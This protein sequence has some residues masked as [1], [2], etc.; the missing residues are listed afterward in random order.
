MGILNIVALLPLDRPKIKC[1]LLPIGVVQQDILLSVMKLDI[2][3]DVYIAEDLIPNVIQM[4]MTNTT[5]VGATL[6]E[7][8]V[9]SWPM[10]AITVKTVIS[11]PQG[12][13]LG[14]NDLATLLQNI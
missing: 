7:T 10:I 8:F 6:K 3:W 14:Y 11:V 5:L 12:I 13:A 1:F 9:P 2:T 4:R